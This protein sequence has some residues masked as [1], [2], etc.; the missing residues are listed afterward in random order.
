MNRKQII[1]RGWHNAGEAFLAEKLTKIFCELTT[2]EDVALHN[3]MVR[4]LHLMV[5]FD[6]RESF[7]MDIA[8]IVLNKPRNFLR[9]VANHIT[10]LS[11]RNLSDG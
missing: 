1:I 5:G 9:S 11:M 2:P 3:D 4:D 8:K 6:N 7:W 10:N